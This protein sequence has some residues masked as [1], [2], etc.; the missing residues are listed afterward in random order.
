MYNSSFAI[1]APSYALN[2]E[3]CTLLSL[4]TEQFTSPPVTHYIILDQQVLKFFA[5]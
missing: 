4:S 3:C 2:F 1:I 5:S